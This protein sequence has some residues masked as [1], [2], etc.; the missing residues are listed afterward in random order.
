MQSRPNYVKY[1]KVFKKLDKKS[2]EDRKLFL[3]HGL[4]GLIAGQ[5]GKLTA[6]QIEAVRRTITSNM[7]RRGKVWI[8]IFPNRPL[9]SKPLESRMGKGKGNV[10][11]WAAFVYPGQILFEVAAGSEKLIVD[12]LKASQVK[13]PIETKIIK[14]PI[15]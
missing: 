5:K 2:K 8:K 13:L 3:N 15:V 9:T 1:N 4:Y 12:A 6:R 7:K 14:R 10:N 11:K